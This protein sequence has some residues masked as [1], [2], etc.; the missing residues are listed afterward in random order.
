MDVITKSYFDDFR[1][2][3]GYVE[4]SD[5]Q[6]FEYFVNYCDVSKYFTMDSITP[7]ML[8]DISTLSVPDVGYDGIAVLANGRLVTHPEELEDVLRGDGYL[9]IRFIFTEVKMAERYDDDSVNHFY[10]AVLASFEYALGRREIDIRKTNKITSF[11]QH[12]YSRSAKF[13][14]NTYP[15]IILLFNTLGSNAPTPAV[16]KSGEEYRERLKATGLFSKVTTEVMGWKEL[17]DM[18]KHSTT[19]EDVELELLRQPIPLPKIQKVQQGYLALVPFK[20]FKKLIIDASGNIKNV[21]SDN[22]RAFQGDNLVNQAI[23]NTL[24]SGDIAIF[25]AMNNGITII[26]GQIKFENSTLTISDY[27]IVNGCQTSHVL[28]RYRNLE[29]IDDLQLLVKFIASSDNEIRTKIIL[30][31]NSQ[32]EVKREQLIALSE[33]QELIEEYY[34]TVKGENRLYYERRSKQ[35][36][37]DNAVPKNKIITIPVQIKAVVS[38][39]IEQPHSIRGYYGSVV[40]KLGSDEIFSEHYRIDIY[41]TSALTLY[42][43]NELFNMSIIPPSYRK[44]KFHMLLAARLQAEK[45]IGKMPSLESKTMEDYC[46]KLNS[47][48]VDKESC[49]QLFIGVVKLIQDCLGREPIDQDN[50][51]RDLTD[52]IFE[53]SKGGKSGQTSRNQAY[54]DYESYIAG[55]VSKGETRLVM[56][57]GLEKAVASFSTLIK[58]SNQKIDILAGN[59]YSLEMNDLNVVEQLDAFLKRG[60]ELHVLMYNYSLEGVQTSRLFKMLAVRFKE[61]RSI[62]VQTKEQAPRMEVRGQKQRYNLFVFDSKHYRL[63][64]EEN[65]TKGNIGIFD[66]MNATTYTTVIE[67]EVADSDVRSLDVLKLFNLDK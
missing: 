45:K 58:I 2:K 37:Y 12:I 10:E 11:L 34:N 64:T 29:G 16:V 49:R 30:G 18:Y 50:D 24:K 4:I 27:Q 14:N 55:L 43:M 44:V 26:A 1:E 40:E 39:F 20:E 35:Y 31:A 5:Y 51:S 63:E 52:R 13:D 3:F 48:L 46:Q 32:T 17:V 9:N 66:T 67:R 47:I 54:S 36:M 7:T 56:S 61:G 42:K 38:M 25:T 21:F 59:L 53:L 65:W 62:N 23:G 60:G 6:A 22:V 28:Y 41:Y 19:K 33:V 15:E 8:D 57:S